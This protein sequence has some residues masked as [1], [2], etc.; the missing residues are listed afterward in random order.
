MFA[1]ETLV[2][3]LA[4]VCSNVAEMGYQRFLILQSTLA[5]AGGNI[6]TFVNKIPHPKIHR[7]SCAMKPSIRVIGLAGYRAWGG[8]FLSKAKS[9]LQILLEI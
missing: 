4:T 8:R 2:A 9:R 5:Q 1:D 6:D 7:R 3:D